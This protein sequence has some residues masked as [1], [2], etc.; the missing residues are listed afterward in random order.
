[1][2]IS[3]NTSSMAM[4]WDRETAGAAVVSSTLDKLNGLP[5]SVSGMGSGGMSAGMSASMS[6]GMDKQMFGA[7]VVSKTLDYMNGPSFGGGKGLSAAMAA[8]Y[9]F[10]KDVLSP[11][12][13]K[14]TILDAIG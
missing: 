5:G 3:F 10:N 2:E 9:A 4:P 14:G 6:A 1:M 13:G 11:L 12:S 7:A 8:D